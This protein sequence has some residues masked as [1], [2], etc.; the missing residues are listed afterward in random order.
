VARGHGHGFNSWKLIYSD[1]QLQF[2]DLKDMA[3]A[4]DF[5]FARK[6]SQ[7]WDFHLFNLERC[8]L[9]ENFR[10]AKIWGGQ[11]SFCPFPC[12]DA[13]GGHHFTKGAAAALTIV[14][15]RTDRRN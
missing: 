5:N 10:H 6:F 2:F 1:R 9:G 11:L 14:K 3:A 4:Q 15:V 7:I 12:H 8:I 13:T